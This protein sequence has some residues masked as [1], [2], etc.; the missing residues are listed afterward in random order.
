MEVGLKI[1][2]P[3]H[4]Q[5]I[6]GKL[7]EA[8]YEAYAVGGCVRD[9][10]IGRIPGDWDITTSAKPGEVKALFAR[11]VDTGIQ[12][13]TVTVLMDKMGYEVTTYRVDGEYEDGRHPREVE[14]TASLLEDLKRRDF[15]IN[16]M[17]YNDRCGIVDIFG[18]RQ[19]LKD[20]IIRCVGD[21]MERFSEDALR[22][23]RAVRFSA[24]LGCTIA[25]S[26]RQAV[27]SLAG[28]LKHISAERIQ[29]ELVKLLL[30]DN[31][32]Y[33]KDAWELGITAVILPEFDAIMKQEQNTPH[34]CFTVGGHTL[35]AMELVKPDKVLRLTMLFHDM[36]KPLVHSSDEE[37]RDRFYGHPDVSEEIAGRVMRRF[38]FDNDTIGKVCRLVKYHDT[39]PVLKPA[40]VRR[41]VHKV[42]NELFLSLLLVQ[43][44]DIR[45]QSTYKREEKL[46]ALLKLKE[47]YQDILRASDCLSL[48]DLKITGKDLIGDGMAPGRELGQVL[49]G[50]LDDVLSEPEHNTKEYLLD[51]AR[52]LRRQYNTP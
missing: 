14:F 6:I 13:G 2:L 36:G 25:E 20:K 9:S 44:A 40:N 37:G 38:R 10:L 49:Q 3:E 12:H 35:K 39:H 16:A 34:H 43:E 32:Q 33:L 45:A 30:S 11:T 26:T 28:N 41:L 51:A 52:K 47:I 48:K 31:P 17:A 15:T 22:I 23:L 46:E 19:D 8:G 1:D 4:V 24:Q 18:G 21:A 42:G 5:A 7:E 27:S 29:A 50:L